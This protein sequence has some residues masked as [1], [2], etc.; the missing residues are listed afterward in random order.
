MWPALGCSQP[1]ALHPEGPQGSPNSCCHK[2]RRNAWAGPLGDCQH[3]CSWPPVESLLR[4]QGYPMPVL[5]VRKA[6]LGHGDEQLRPR[7]GLHTPRKCSPSLGNSR[8]SQTSPQ[9]IH[10]ELI[11]RKQQRGLHGLRQLSASFK[12][13]SGEGSSFPSWSCRSEAHLGVGVRGSRQ[14]GETGGGGRGRVVW[15]VVPGLAP[16]SE[17]TGSHP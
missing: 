17:T 14:R 12:R 6:R 5:Q 10:R 7:T 2:E 16:C 9:L 11:Q 15:W 4:P 1:P 13:A 8:M 3:P